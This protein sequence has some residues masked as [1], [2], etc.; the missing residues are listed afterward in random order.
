[1]PLR[2]KTTKGKIHEQAGHLM[3]KSPKYSAREAYGVATGIVTGQKPRKKGQ[4]QMP[5]KRKRYGYGGGSSHM[6]RGMSY[7]N[8]PQG[9]RSDEGKPM[10]Y[11]GK[12][13]Q[14]YID[15][16]GMPNAGKVKKVMDYMSNYYSTQGVKYAGYDMGENRAG[17]VG[18]SSVNAGTDPNVSSMDP[19]YKQMKYS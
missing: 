6:D 18:T 3:A 10:G 8:A 13:P 7:A 19:T 4:K 17:N 5:H 1:M 2:A 14:G 9:Y 11:Y 12:P 15:Q 16:S